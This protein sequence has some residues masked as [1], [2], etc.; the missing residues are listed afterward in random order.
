MKAVPFASVPLGGWFKTSKDG[1]WHL[2]ASAG[3]G[4]YQRFGTRYEPR[5]SADEAVLVD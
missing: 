3:T 5:F 1:D 2:K 4:M